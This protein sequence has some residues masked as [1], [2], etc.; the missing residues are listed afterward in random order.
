M[1]CEKLTMKIYEG[2][3]SFLIVILSSFAATDYGCDISG[4]TPVFMSAYFC[5]GLYRQLGADAHRHAYF[6]LW[7]S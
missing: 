5:M 6:K 3:G 1:H 7:E 2:I 4:A